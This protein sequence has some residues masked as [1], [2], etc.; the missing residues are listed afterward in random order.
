MTQKPRLHVNHRPSPTHPH[1]SAEPW[2]KWLKSSSDGLNPVEKILVKM[3]ILPII[4][5]NIKI[6]ETTN[7]EIIDQD[8]SKSSAYPSV[9]VR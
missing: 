7:Q 8:T 6:F 3:G 4:G 5:M 9:P 2:L 1:V